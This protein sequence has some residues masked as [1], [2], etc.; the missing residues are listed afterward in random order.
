MLPWRRCSNVLP[1]PFLDAPLFRSQWS[2]DD[3]ENEDEDEEELFAV[4]G[5]E[6][7]AVVA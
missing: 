3:G 7:W 6:N 2:P 5:S 1:V 4:A